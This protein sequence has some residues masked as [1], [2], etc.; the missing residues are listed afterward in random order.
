MIIINNS[1]LL[2]FNRGEESNEYIN[3]IL[4]LLQEM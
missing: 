4:L 3:I 2:L 1:N